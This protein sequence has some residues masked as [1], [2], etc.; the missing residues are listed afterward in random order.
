MKFFEVV[1]DQIRFSFVRI[2]FSSVSL[3]A[4]ALI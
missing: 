1:G 4:L 2:F 3:E